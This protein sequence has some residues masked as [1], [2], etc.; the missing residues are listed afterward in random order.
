MSRKIRDRMSREERWPVASRGR[1]RTVPPVP[2]KASGT[3]ERHSDCAEARA[4]NDRPRIGGL[5]PGK[6]E[7]AC[8]QSW[9]RSDPRAR[10]REAYKSA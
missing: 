5:D 8:L 7:Y 10:R 2:E 9:K 3:I 4:F 6:L 1:R